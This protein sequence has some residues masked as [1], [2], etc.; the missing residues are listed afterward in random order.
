[1]R[2][3]NY[4]LALPKRLKQRSHLIPDK[5]CIICKVGEK[6]WK[7]T[8]NEKEAENA[9]FKYETR[10]IKDCLK[11]EQIQEYEVIEG[12]LFYQGRINP[13]NQLKTQD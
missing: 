12:I 9:S 3:I 10:V 11:L 2:I 4:L 8:G 13:V 5:S 1:M 7:P 6:L